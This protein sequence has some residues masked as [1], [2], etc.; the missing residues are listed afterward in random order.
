MNSNFENLIKNSKYSFKDYRKYLNERT[1]EN[2][3][4]VDPRIDV[5]AS[6]PDFGQCITLSVLL[7]GGVTYSRGI[8]PGLATTGVVAGLTYINYLNRMSSDALEKSKLV[9]LL[10]ESG[11]I[12][13]SKKGSSIITPKI[14]KTLNEYTNDNQEPLNIIGLNSGKLEYSANKI[15]RGI[16]KNPYS[17]KAIEKASINVMKYDF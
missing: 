7:G 17:Q 16:F 14:I 2:N 1:E 3:Q 4:V 13:T 10:K 9:E 12:E 11:N 5:S 8:V 15:T 6:E